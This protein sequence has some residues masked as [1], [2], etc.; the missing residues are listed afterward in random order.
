MRSN[1]TIKPLVF[2]EERS[3]IEEE[4]LSTLNHNVISY[5]SGY[6]VR[7]IKE[8]CCII[9]KDEI[10]SKQQEI[11]DHQF[12]LTKQYVGCKDGLVLPSS[13]FVRAIKEMERGLL[14]SDFQHVT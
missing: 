3:P 5:L 7:N 11:T 8:K 10:G 6:A 4:V 2:Q 13:S 12:I 9:C 1:R 14:I